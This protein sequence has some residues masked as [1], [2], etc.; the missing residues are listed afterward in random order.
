MGQMQHRQENKA[1]AVMFINF[2]DLGIHGFLTR[3]PRASSNQKFFV[4]HTV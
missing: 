1:I 4:P 2:V 3:R